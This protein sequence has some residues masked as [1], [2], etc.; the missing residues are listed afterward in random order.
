M[1]K[2]TIS[3]P[4]KKVI[5][6]LANEL[7]NFIGK[8]QYEKKIYQIEVYWQDKLIGRIYNTHS[9]YFMFYFKFTPFLNACCNYDSRPIAC[10]SFKY[11]DREHNIEKKINRIK[12]MFLAFK[13]QA[14]EYF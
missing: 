3:N 10:I 5:A 9:Y 6:Q 4:S 7:C 2:I 13:K 11:S 1:E 12:S 8:I 14:K